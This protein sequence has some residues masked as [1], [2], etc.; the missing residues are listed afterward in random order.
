M[1][2]LLVAILAF[3]TVAAFSAEDQKTTP[4]SESTPLD[5]ET[6][7]KATGILAIPPGKQ[8]PDAELVASKRRHA[9][10]VRLYVEPAKERLKGAPYAEK[11]GAF[12]F[13]NGFFLFVILFRSKHVLTK[14]H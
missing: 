6:L 4:P 2:I 8:D 5:F 3:G 13:L 7:S 10:L 1:R 14:K 9:R 11:I 12:L